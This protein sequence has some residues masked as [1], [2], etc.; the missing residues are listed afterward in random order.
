LFIGFNGGGHHIVTK[1]GTLRTV[2]VEGH[3]DDPPLSLFPILSP[4]KFADV[5]GN[6]ILMTL[7]TETGLSSPK[8]LVN[9]FFACSFLTLIKI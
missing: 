5:A 2:I 1:I 7:T 4:H 9:I 3:G 8:I 6:L